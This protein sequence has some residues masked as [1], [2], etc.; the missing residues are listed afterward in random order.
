MCAAGLSAA[1]PP[2]AAPEP[3]AGLEH[4]AYRQLRRRVGPAGGGAAAAGR[5]LRAPGLPRPDPAPADRHVR[6][7]RARTRRPGHPPA[8][9]PARAPRPSAQRSCTAAR[10][11]CSATRWRPCC[12]PRAR[13][14]SCTFTALHDTVTA[15]PA[16]HWPLHAHFLLSG[17]LLAHSVAG[18]DPAPA[19]PGVRARLVCL[20]CAIAV[21][22]VVAQLMYGLGSGCASTAPVAEVR[23]GAEIMY[24]GGDIAELLLA[25]ALVATWRP[26]R[27]A[28]RAPAV[29]TT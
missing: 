11:A 22:A 4:L 19:R 1:G 12:C 25:A 20:G 28:I 29:R 16:G 9:H 6:A 18:P 5:T 21:H 2:G 15:H 14:R 23:G 27:R 10:P 26:E 8:A 17:C 13:F 7:P 3:G 24:Y